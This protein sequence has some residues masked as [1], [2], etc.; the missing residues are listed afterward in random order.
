MRC[1][2][3]NV[4][5]TT[6]HTKVCRICG[7]ERKCPF[8]Q[9]ETNHNTYSTHAPLVPVYSRKKRFVRLLA[10]VLAPGPQPGDDKMLEYLFG[11]RPVEDTDALLELMKA[12]PVKDKRYCSLH[13]F[14]KLCVPAYVA[15]V[16]PS[17]LAHLQRLMLRCFEEVEFAHRRF[18]RGDHMFFNYGW[19]L[20]LYL[21][22]FGLHQYLRFVKP[23]KCRHRRE[24]YELMY[25][26]IMRLDTLPRALGDVLETHKPLF[27]RA[28]GHPTTPFQ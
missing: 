17:N 20:Q 3:E 2:G 19:I 23:L 5:F 21:R 13:L 22:V 24:T 16:P 11:H 6:R 15:P 10:S 26:E 7:L 12:S 18:F 27:E 9:T 4:L 14:V 25:L 1:C 8:S 28:D